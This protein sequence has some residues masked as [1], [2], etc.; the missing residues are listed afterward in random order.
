[1][2]TFTIDDRDLDDLIRRDIWQVVREQ[3]PRP[4][5]TLSVALVLQWVHSLAAAIALG[6]ALAW[7]YSLFEEIRRVRPWYASH[8]GSR[9]GPLTVEFREEGLYTIMPLGEGVMRWDQLDSIKNYSSCFVL[10]LDGD[11]VLILP[12]RHFSTEELIVLQAKAA[13]V[14]SRRSR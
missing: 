2:A 12:K 3:G 9:A 14:E 11:E 7:A 4:A 6:M 13:E 10:E 1:M 5:A 8:H